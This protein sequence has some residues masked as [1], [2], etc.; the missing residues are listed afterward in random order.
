M[1]PT[2]FTLEPLNTVALDRFVGV[3][4]TSAGIWT[5]PRAD[6][7][8]NLRVLD[9]G[10]EVGVVGQIY[11]TDRSLHWF[12][13]GL[14]ENDDRIE[15]MLAF[16]L[17]D[18]D[19]PDLDHLEEH[20]WRVVLTG[21]ATLSDGELAVV[22]TPSHHR[23]R[24]A[25]PKGQVRVVDNW[26]V[27]AV[28][29]NPTIRIDLRLLDRV[30]Q[31]EDSLILER[32]ELEISVDTADTPE[33]MAAIAR[34]VDV[35]SSESPSLERFVFVGDDPIVYRDRMIHI[36]RLKYRVNEVSDYAL[37]GANLPLPG[38]MLVQAALAML[39]VEQ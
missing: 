11:E 33:V 31:E 25:R 16:D 15:W 22:G 26:L 30:A 28:A 21:H 29:P 39:V 34:R 3:C 14:A 10:D 4:L 37:A 38:G 19:S 7:I 23:R 13:F 9:C 1:L 32:G 5:E 6:G 35:A 2:L 36:G 17:P 24:S 20:A 12:M 8:P 18:E 27:F